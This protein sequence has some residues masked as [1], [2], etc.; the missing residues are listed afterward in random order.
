[1]ATWH[2]STWTPMMVVVGP[3][4]W[5]SAFVADEAPRGVPRESTEPSTEKC[6]Q[7]STEQSAGTSMERSLGRGLD[8]STELSTEKCVQRGPESSTGRST[9]ERTAASRPLIVE[10]S[11]GAYHALRAAETWDSPRALFC[12][13]SGPDRG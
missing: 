10:Q 7:R 1:M 3:N 13:I 8:R 6:A 5:W 12:V 2:F 4:L 9:G 11:R